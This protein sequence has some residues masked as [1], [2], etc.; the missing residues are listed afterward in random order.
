[1]SV[2]RSWRFRTMQM[3]CK[4]I[5]NRVSRFFPHVWSHDPFIHMYF[6]DTADKLPKNFQ[7]FWCDTPP[8][9]RPWFLTVAFRFD[10]HAKSEVTLRDIRELESVHRLPFLRIK[11]IP[12]YHPSGSRSDITETAPILNTICEYLWQRDV[13]FNDQSHASAYHSGEELATYV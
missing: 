7:I 5:T 2:G 3:T 8:Y 9:F 11:N 4:R 12:V 13:A 6:F 10:Q 1:M